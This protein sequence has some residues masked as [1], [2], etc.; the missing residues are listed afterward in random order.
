MT[1]SELHVYLSRWKY[2]TPDEASLQT[3]VRTA[4]QHTAI[5]FEEQVEI[6]PGVSRIDFLVGAVGIELKVDGSTNAVIRQLHRYAD[7]PRVSELLLVTTRAKHICVPRLLA[8][9]PV[10]LL[11]IR[12]FA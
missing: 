1:A 5:S 10:E 3:A 6:T 12:G 7:S 2:A 11:L 4:L 8:G 9:K